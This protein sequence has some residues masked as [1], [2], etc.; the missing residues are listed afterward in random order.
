MSG[1]AVAAVTVDKISCSRTQ[2]SALRELAE[3]EC[4]KITSIH[5]S[6]PSIPLDPTH[7]MDPTHHINLD[8]QGVHGVVPD[9]VV[10]CIH[11]DLIKDLVQP[12]YKG[13]AL[14]HHALAIMH[15]ENLGLL[16]S[17]ADVCVW[18]QQDVLQLGLLLIDVLDGLASS[19]SCRGRLGCTAGCSCRLGH[20]GHIGQRQGC[21][22]S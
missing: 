4:T 1:S 9:L 5:A 16:L 3:I 12:W 14:L 21:A 20:I 7:P 11:Q 6:D 17:A 2:C 18:A 13:D 19:C 15:P 22:G 10:R 8:F